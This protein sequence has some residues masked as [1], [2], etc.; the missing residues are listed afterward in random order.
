MPRFEPNDKLLL[1]AIGVLAGAAAA[2][3]IVYDGLGLA[4]GIGLPLWAAAL[5]VALASQ[6]GTGSRVGLPVLGMAMVGLVIHVA[7]GH[8]E[9]HFAVFAFLATTIVYRHWLPV[10][11][12]A[13]TI[14]VHHLSFNFFQSWGWGPVCFTEPGLWRVV[15]HAAYV[16]GEAAILIMLAARSQSDFAANEQLS[17]I[18]DGLVLRFTK[19]LT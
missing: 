11:A 18:A 6:G 14:A 12:G 5:A 7:R 1:V 9:A 16:V 17:R 13:A 8:T 3:G 10:V 19:T 2:Y 4:L 15:E